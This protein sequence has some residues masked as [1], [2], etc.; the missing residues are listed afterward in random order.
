MGYIGKNRGMTLS[1]FMLLLFVLIGSLKLED[2]DAAVIRTGV[3]SIGVSNVRIGPSTSYT[4]LKHGSKEI[5]LKMGQTVTITN[6]NTSW[7]KVNFYYSRRAYSGFI[8]KSNVKIKVP[9]LYY[10][11]RVNTN[12]LNVRKSASTNSQQ[13]T[14][15]GKVVQLNK[16]KNVH[17]MKIVKDWYYVRFGY[18]TK[19]YYGYVASKYVN[20]LSFTG[21][22]SASALYVRSGAD[23]SKSIVKVGKE[24]VKLIKNTTVTITGVADK[25]Y[26]ISAKFKGKT[27]K[28][29]VYSSYLTGIKEIVK[30]VPKA[31]TTSSTD[32]E[33]ENAVVKIAFTTATGLNVRTGA[34]TSY[35]VLSS[36]GNKV[37]LEK[38]TVV[39]IISSK[40]SWHYVSFKFDNKDLKG[41]VS[42]DYVTTLGINSKGAYGIDVSQYQGTINWRQVKAS[43]IDFAIIRATKYSSNGE[44]GTKLTKDSKFET[45]IK[46]AIAAGIKVG[47]YVYSYADTVAEVV[48]E[49]EL[50]CSY[51]KGYKLTYPVYFDIEEGSRQKV[52]L[53]AANTNFA[54]AFCEK[55]KDLGYRPGVYTG[56]GFFV[57]YLDVVVDGKFI[58]SL[59][60]SNLIF[61]GSSNQRII[62]VKETLKQNKV[63][64]DRLNDERLS[65][66]KQD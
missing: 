14:I 36:R 46:G 44:K 63:V 47:V 61:K 30:V 21:K 66:G 62:D 24:N 60:Q 15:G 56:A 12:K 37:V 1:I 3:I 28:G 26:Y 51:V 9:A 18:G 41:Y 23:I 32:K 29:Y 43:G 50:V 54:I 52:A 40:G 35:S 19:Y 25:W 55:V 31:P 65:Y 4:C 57:N 48:K 58:N 64:L 10:K 20:K 5:K 42:S 49:A 34:G 22:I 59:K 45:N 27:I 38:G 7:Y 16:N 8:K 6:E 17:I 2:V 39:N 33:D 53:K 11:G 13:L